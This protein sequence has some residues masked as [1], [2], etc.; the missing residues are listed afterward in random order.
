[1]KNFTKCE[2]FCVFFFLWPNT[3]L[4]SSLSDLLLSKPKNI[5]SA[6]FHC[7]STSTFSCSFFPLMLF[8]CFFFPQRYFILTHLKFSLIHIF[9]V[10]DFLLILFL[11]IWFHWWCSLLTP[12]PHIIND[13]TTTGNNL[14]LSCTCSC[15]CDIYV[16][17]IYFSLELLQ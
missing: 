2:K 5:P 12:F 11:I 14:A 17:D 9:N 10:S 6:I 3:V 8:C 4:S 7:S 13:D 15:V 1:M 16:G